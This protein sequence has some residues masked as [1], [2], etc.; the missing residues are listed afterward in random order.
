MQDLIGD[1]RRLI[2]GLRPPALD[3]LG[4]AASLRGL[5]EQETVAGTTVTVTAPAAMPTLPAAVEVAA[6]WIA[7]E[8]LTNVEATCWC[9][10]VRGTPARG[11]G[12]LRLEIADDGKGLDAARA[13]SGCTP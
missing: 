2:Y 10:H 1:V 3:Q 8:A 4:L 13:A 9:A 11:A 5:A 12:V 7:Q 6:Y